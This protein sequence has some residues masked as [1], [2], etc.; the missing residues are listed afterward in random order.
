VNFLHKNISTENR[1]FSQGNRITIHHLSEH[2]KDLK[3]FFRKS[4]PTTITTSIIHVRK[5]LEAVNGIVTGP[6]FF[7]KWIHVDAV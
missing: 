1:F 2:M 5:S 6:S 7:I 3:P 4:T